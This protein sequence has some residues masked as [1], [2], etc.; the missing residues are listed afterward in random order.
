VFK[1]D[2]L[3]YSFRVLF[4]PFFFVGKKQWEEKR[5]G[6]KWE[7]FQKFSFSFKKEKKA[8]KKRPLLFSPLS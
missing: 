6:K 5:M 2:V 4:F 8:K 1:L 7:N 3:D